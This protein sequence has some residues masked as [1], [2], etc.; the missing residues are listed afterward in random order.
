MFWNSLSPN[1]SRSIWRK[2]LRQRE[3]P[4]GSNGILVPLTRKQGRRLSKS[5]TTDDVSK[6]SRISDLFSCAI[7]SSL[8]H[9]SV[10]RLAPSADHQFPSAPQQNQASLQSKRKKKKLYPS[11]NTKQK[12]RWALENVVGVALKLLFFN[13]LGR[14]RICRKK[15]QFLP[16]TTA[17]RTQNYWNLESGIWNPN[18]N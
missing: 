10:L 2:Q 11:I 1:G 15:H 9:V 5:L 3:S 12:V 8:L 17:T 6:Y 4:V 7:F 18:I 14:T 16:T 13:S